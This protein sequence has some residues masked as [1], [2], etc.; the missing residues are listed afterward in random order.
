M[1]D[2]HD[3]ENMDDLYDSQGLGRRVNELLLLSALRRRPAHGYQLALEIE[4]QSG[5][6]FSFNHGT[7]YPI[8]HRLETEGLIAG[9]WSDPDTG[10]PR[11]QYSLTEAGRTRLA[12]GVREWRNLSRRLDSFLD[13]GGARGE[14]LEG[15]APGVDDEQ[16]R[17]GAA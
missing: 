4:E 12:E 14:G 3:H 16:V 6:Y 7:L 1:D 2:L 8:L 9:E 10:R 13:T 5:G 11:K 17:S 15:R